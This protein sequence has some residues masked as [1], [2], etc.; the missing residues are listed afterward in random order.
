MLLGN[1]EFQNKTISTWAL[2]QLEMKH[3]LLTYL[4]K[5]IPTPNLYLYKPIPKPYLG[6][7]TKTMMRKFLQ[8]DY[9]KISC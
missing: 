2:R 6:T 8:N 1:S 7:F 4:Y 5:P 3:N 9:S